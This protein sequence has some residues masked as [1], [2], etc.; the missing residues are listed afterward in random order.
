[1][2]RVAC[3]L[4]QL[5]GDVTLL[6]FIFIFYSFFFLSFF[7]TNSPNMDPGV[8]TEL[9]QREGNAECAECAMKGQEKGKRKWNQNKSKLKN[10]TEIKLK[11]IHEN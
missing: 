6:F 5:M 10:F 2:L 3:L 9:L 11:L 7:F 4:V 1:M 8:L